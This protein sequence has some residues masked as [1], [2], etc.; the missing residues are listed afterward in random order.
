MTDEKK[1]PAPAGG[2]RPLDVLLAVA[3][4]VVTLG[5]LGLSSEVSRISRRE[6][7]LWRRL[8]ELS[9]TVYDQRRRA[10]VTAAEVDRLQYV[11]RR[12]GCGE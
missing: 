3:F 12:C 1:E 5:A 2:I 8:D 11:T 9:G 4:V 7:A 6:E 10:S